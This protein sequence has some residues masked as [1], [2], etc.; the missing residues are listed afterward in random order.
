MGSL[1]IHIKWSYVLGSPN[2]GLCP[3]TPAPNVD[4]EAFKKNIT[5]VNVDREAFDEFCVNL[6]LILPNC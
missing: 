6:K 4:R 2:R 3:Q 1:P 5:P